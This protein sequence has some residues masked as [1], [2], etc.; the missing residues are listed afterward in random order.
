MAPV[1]VA[2]ALL[3]G[4]ELG[5]A[6]LAGAD[7]TDADAEEADVPAEVADGTVDPALDDDPVQPLSAMLIAPAQSRTD[8]LARAPPIVP[9]QGTYSCP[10]PLSG[11]VRAEPSRIEEACDLQPP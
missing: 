2:D 11:A 6:E 8:M 10:G 1:A 7:E 4:A 5:G 9:M 3:A